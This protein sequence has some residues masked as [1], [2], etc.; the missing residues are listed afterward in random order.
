MKAI[1]VRL[2]YVAVGGVIVLAAMVFLRVAC[3]YWDRIW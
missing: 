2:F 3:R 1:A